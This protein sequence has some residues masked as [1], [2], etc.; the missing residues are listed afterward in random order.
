MTQTAAVWA[1]T[2]I[3][4]LLESLQGEQASQ[5]TPPLEVGSLVS[6]YRKAGKRL[7]LFDYGRSQE[8][9]AVAARGDGC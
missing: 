5:N 6:K 2:N 4:K 8:G 7:L 9:C 3:L 1:H